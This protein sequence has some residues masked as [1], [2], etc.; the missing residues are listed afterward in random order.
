MFKHFRV[1]HL[2]FILKCAI[3]I[4]FYLTFTFKVFQNMQMEDK[5]KILTDAE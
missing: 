1:K 5:K 3:Q 4:K 2:I